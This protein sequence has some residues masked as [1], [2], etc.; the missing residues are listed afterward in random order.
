VATFKAEFLSHYW[1][2]RMRPLHAYAFGWIDK[3]ARL[4]SVAPRLASLFTQAPGLSTL[5]KAVAGI[6]QQRT[7]PAFATQTFKSWFGKRE[8]HNQGKPRV[9]LWAD[10]FNNYFKP[11]TSQAAVEVL[12]SAGYQ[13]VV[14][15]QHLCCG[16]PLYD[17]GFLDMAK[18]YLQRVLAALEP[19]IEAGTP[20]VALEPSCGSVFRDDLTGLMPESKAAQKLAQQTFTLAEF[21]EK[22]GCAVPKVE[23]KAIVHGHCHHKAIM[24]LKEEKQVMDKMGLEYRLLESG[25]CGMA[26]AFGY[27]KEHYDVSVAVGERVLLPEVRKAEES[28]LIIADGFSCQSQIEQQAGRKALHLAEVLAM[29][30]KRL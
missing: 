3:W 7:I 15:Q 10:T 4:A 23:R 5:A 28:T 12:E 6:P 24:R 20:M 18:S 13:V 25:C 22:N 14:P 1:E 29:G 17:Y 11:Q 27:E 26:G 21:L 16:R 9:I 19:E 2:G 8:P 30:V